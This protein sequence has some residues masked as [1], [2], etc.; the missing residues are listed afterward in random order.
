MAAAGDGA[1]GF[2]RMLRCRDA[3][4][5]GVLFSSDYSGM[6]CERDAM[7]AAFDASTDAF[8]ALEWGIG[9]F[10]PRIE[11]TRSCDHNPV[12][13]HVL[14]YS[15]KETDASQSCV[16]SSIEDQIPLA[17]R[18]Y[19]ESLM[20]PRGSELATWTEANRL[21]DKFLM[22]NREWI[23]KATN[24][25]P[26]LVHERNCHLVPPAHV[27]PRCMRVNSAGNACWAWSSVGIQAREADSTE[28]PWF[29]WLRARQR[30][31]ELKVR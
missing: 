24:E 28:A 1:S 13:R 5:D 25:C 17:A 19:I 6:G 30:F 27:E 16:F 10:S 20:P 9:R 21:I 26:C 22:E 4:A 23:Y 31:A 7:S 8:S 2:E 3:L 29:I 15:A 14:I 12:A 18:E 11:F